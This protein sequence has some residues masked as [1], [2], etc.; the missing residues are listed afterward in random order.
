[1]PEQWKPV[2]GYEGLYEVS[3]HGRVRSLDKVVNSSVCTTGLRLRK[4]RLLKQSL[5]KSG[6]CTVQL[7]TNGKKTA[8]R[9]Y[10]HHLVLE[11]F[12]GPRPEGLE[13]LHG[14]DDKL[15]NTPSN[16]RWDTR[17]ANCREMVE[18]GRHNNKHNYRNV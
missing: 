2:V 9:R 7:Y 11:A 14:D 3:D 17:L 15:N 13:C 4:G 16:L 6:Y 5:T 8:K 18:R 12:V 10:V 1:M